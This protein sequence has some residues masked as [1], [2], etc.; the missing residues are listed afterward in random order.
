MDLNGTEIS[1][2]RRISFKKGA[3]HP[4]PIDGL[5]VMAPLLCTGV[6][7]LFCDQLRAG[8]RIGRL[9]IEVVTKNIRV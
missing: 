4:C 7:K 3:H 6:E 8:Q 9:C 5:E 1:K 2:R